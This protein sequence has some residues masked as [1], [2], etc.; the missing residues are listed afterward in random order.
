MTEVTLLEMTRTNQS[1]VF[2]ENKSR[3][4]PGN[5]SYT[6][7]S[8]IHFIKAQLWFRIM[9]FSFFLSYIVPT[10]LLI[11]T[12]PMDT[13]NITF[14]KLFVDRYLTSD[15]SILFST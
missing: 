7:L 6:Q 12:E 8:I 3:L 13:K 5:T 1:C 11:I 15:I 9:F 2:E 4:I 10:T 14:G